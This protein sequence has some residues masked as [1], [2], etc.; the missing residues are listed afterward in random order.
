VVA[1]V[2][3]RVDVV[4]DVPVVLAQEAVAEVFEGLA[5]GSRPWASAIQEMIFELQQPDRPVA[6]D[7]GPGSLIVKRR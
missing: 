2:Q 3:Q 4:F 6:G 5:A 1:E 7:Q